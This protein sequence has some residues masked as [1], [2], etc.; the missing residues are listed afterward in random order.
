MP[1]RHPERSVLKGPE[2]A[3]PP[4]IGQHFRLLGRLGMEA[5]GT[6]ADHLYLV[7]PGLVQQQPERI[8]REQIVGVGKLDELTP[9]RCKTRIARGGRT[10]VPPQGNDGY[11]CIPFCKLLENF[12]RSIRRCIINTDYFER[13]QRLGDELPRVQSDGGANRAGFAPLELAAGI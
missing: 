8:M 9:R 1:P 11:P 4:G 3:P 13:A 6:T 5:H 2:P 7:R 12:A 10:P